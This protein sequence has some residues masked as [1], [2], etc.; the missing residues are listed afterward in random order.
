MI[1]TPLSKT[2]VRRLVDHMGTI[3]QPWV[4]NQ[5]VDQNYFDSIFSF[6]FRLILL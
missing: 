2:D 3:E 4:T 5:I 1:G 6:C